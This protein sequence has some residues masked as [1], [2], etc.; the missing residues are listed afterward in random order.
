M[1]FVILFEIRNVALSPPFYMVCVY[2]AES[3]NVM[4]QIL[5]P[6]DNIKVGASLHFGISGCG[7]DGCTGDIAL[8]FAK[9][10][11]S[12]HGMEGRR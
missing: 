1:L 3:L 8:D 2:V 11:S 4:Q 12:G 10:M 9:C 7:A 5:A 6:E